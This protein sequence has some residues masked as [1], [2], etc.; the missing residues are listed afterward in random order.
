MQ[1]RAEGREPVSSPEELATAAR[2]CPA[3]AEA[4][5]LAEWVGP[6]R[7]LTARGVLKPAAA[8]EAC[9]LL[10]I[11]LT[12]RKPRS[13]LDIGPL[14]MAWFAA[15]A[16]GFV[17]V[18]RGR[19]TA[20]AALET[21][22][23]GTADEVLTV[24]TRCTMECFGVAGEA[25]EPDPEVLDGLTV[26]YER[27]GT[28][29][30]D[31][32]S[33][34]IAGVLAADVAPGCT[35]PSCE[36]AAGLHDDLA[37]TTEDSGEIVEA[38]AEFGL[39]VLRGKTAEL[40]PLGH[41]FTDFLFRRNAPAAGADAATL[42]NAVV[43]LPDRM[44][45][46]L[47]RPWLSARSPAE[48]AAELIAA[49]ESS[50][51]PQRPAALELARACGPDAAPAWREWAGR[52]G[53]GAYARIWL[54]E[55]DGTEPAENDLAWTAVDA[56]GILQDTLAPDL[57]PHPLSGL[58]QDQ[59]GAELAEIL[60][61][62][63]GTGHPAADRLVKLLP[64]PPM[65]RR[66]D[67]PPDA[68]VRTGAPPPAAAVRPDTRYRIKLAL[69]DVT[70]P[71]VWRRLEVP[72][73][74]DLGQVHEV[75]QTAMGW[76]NCHLH[77]FS[78]GDAEYGMPDPD[79]GHADERAVRLSQ[80]LTEAGDR[81]GYT[82]DFGDGWEHDLTLEEILP[83]EAGTTGAICT[84]G[85]GAC[86][87]E[88]CGGPYGYQELKAILADPGDDQHEDMLEWLGVASPGDFDPHA[89]SA[90]D[91]NRRLDQLTGR[92]LRIVR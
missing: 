83:A 90:E 92:H 43:A 16:A 45:A 8:V 7:P 2:N 77:V 88:D 37:G 54:A 59:A 24:W 80:L 9:D 38:L 17:E 46:L 71:P 53:F 49:G 74:L 61:L 11:E 87:P 33:E 82:Y 84:V 69:R 41:W 20:G 66:R 42:V 73:D 70:H 52:E 14:M 55:H 6:G 18:E 64:V 29:S 35:C 39:A 21:W 86:P 25:G 12:T 22:A 4:A 23:K 58:S 10:G 79:L 47:A 65:A 78:A 51:G 34:D 30:L 3:L 5:K 91:A 56:L 81:L 50:S 44:A 26:L 76:E 75:I 89:F 27:G 19:A 72:A 31:D 67:S 28:I 32:L 15:S 13:A 1:S 36:W 62:L 63:A 57:S 68:L 85:K 48:A 60:P 40:T